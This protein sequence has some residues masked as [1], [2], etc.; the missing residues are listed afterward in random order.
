MN[1]IRLAKFL[2][3]SRA[4]GPGLRDV[5][6]TAGCSIHC[7]GCINP[8]LLDARGGVDVPLAEIEEVID[9][10]RDAIEGI[11]FSGGEPADQPTAVAHLAR[12]ARSRGLS[13][14]LFTGRTLEECMQHR[15]RRELIAACDLVLAGPYD[16]NAAQRTAPLLGS[17]NQRIH[18]VTQRY[19]PDDLAEV[20]DAEIVMT[21]TRFVLSGL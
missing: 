19:G 20:P 4:N 8:H 12:F 17:A 11:T 10:R 18:F 3:G 13:V 5:F 1:R 2:A 6:W 16:R 9:S 21:G 14:V 7:P 15:G